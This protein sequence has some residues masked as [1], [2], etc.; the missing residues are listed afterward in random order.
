MEIFGTL[1]LTLIAGLSTC[2]GYFFTYI[3]S[4]NI[5]KLVCIS[6]SFAMGVM[7]LISIKELIPSPIKYILITNNIYTSLS[8]IISIPIIIYL[9][10]F[11]VNKIIKNNNSLYRV[12]VLNTLTLILHNIPE[13]IVTFMSS[14]INIKL[15][16]KLTLAIIAHNIP[17]GICISIPIYYATKNRKKAFIY[18]LIAGISEL[19]GAL[20]VYILFNKYITSSILNIILYSIGCLMIIIS[21]K[22]ILPEVLK[23]NNYLWILIGILLSLFILLL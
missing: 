18:T 15:G 23:Y 1:M 16:L 21:I 19:F 2:L 13:G 6:L 17:E 7:I 11:L 12:G 22:E 8:I 14:K 4:K 5:D 10:F 20:L 3:K 9:L